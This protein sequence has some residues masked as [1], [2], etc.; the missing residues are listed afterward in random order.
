MGKR[1]ALH[2]MRRQSPSTT[3]LDGCT[4]SALSGHPPTRKQYE[5]LDNVPTPH[6][7]AILDDYQTVMTTL[8]SHCA[9]YLSGS[10]ADKLDFN[11]LG[12][13]RHFAPSPLVLPRLVPAAA[14]LRFGS[15]D[16][17]LRY[18]AHRHDTLITRSSHRLSLVVFLPLYLKCFIRFPGTLQCPR[19]RARCCSSKAVQGRPT[20]LQR[21]TLDSP[22]VSIALHNR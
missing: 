1:V 3:Y 8:L 18:T 20:G 22:M 13:G 14:Q 11:V 6:Y 2:L 21:A 4:G 16:A 5:R 9:R 10:I 19:L 17:V 12:S 7:Q 15:G